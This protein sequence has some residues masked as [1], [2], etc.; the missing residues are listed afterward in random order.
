M[1][2][3]SHLY[4]GSDWLRLRNT[5]QDYGH[6]AL[7]HLSWWECEGSG[8]GPYAGADTLLVT[9]LCNI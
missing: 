8:G 4:T 7:A 2:L 9:A 5:D 6:L 1:F 3:P